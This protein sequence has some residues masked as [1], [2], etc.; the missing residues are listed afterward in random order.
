MSFSYGSDILL[1]DELNS[2]VVAI[3]ITT[4]FDRIRFMYIYYRIS[5]TWP[6]VHSHFARDLSKMDAQPKEEDDEPS[7]ASSSS[8]SSEE[9]DKETEE[10]QRRRLEEIKKAKA[11]EENRKK[12]MESQQKSMSKKVCTIVVP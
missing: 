12:L 10:E 7:V 6:C 5:D 3:M 11:E 9:E 1:I 2:L 8:S 4:C